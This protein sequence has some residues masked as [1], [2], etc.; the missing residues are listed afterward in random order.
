MNTEK[1]KIDLARQLARE[2]KMHPLAKARVLS[3]ITRYENGGIVAQGNEF[4]CIY[5]LDEIIENLQRM[6]KQ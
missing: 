6:A 1:R 4:K 5:S 3:E 2:A